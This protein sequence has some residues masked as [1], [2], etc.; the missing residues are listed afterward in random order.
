MT[1]SKVDRYLLDT[2]ALLAHYR[3]EPGAAVVHS[4]LEDDQKDIL[5]CAASITE[6]A[7]R[8]QALGAG[9]EDTR[10]AALDYAGLASEVVAI[11]AALATR[12]F[13]LG[14]LAS[15]RLPL[16]DAFIASAASIRNAVLVH[17]DSHFTSLPSDMLSQMFLG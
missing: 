5:I 14:N 8:L 10:K 1:E 7:R 15:E 11:D 9:R 6:F 13:E 17:R 2:T 3:G 4:L 12:A 16:V